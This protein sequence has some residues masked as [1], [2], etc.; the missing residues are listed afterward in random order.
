MAN[1]SKILE[2]AATGL[3]VTNLE[4]LPA[5]DFWQSGVISLDGADT[6]IYD[7]IMIV[8][9]EIVLAASPTDGDAVEFYL[10]AGDDEAS[11]TW[12]GNIGE[13]EGTISTAAAVADV[14][15]ALPTPHHL[16]AYVSGANLTLKGS[17][18]IA[19]PTH[20]VQILVRSPDQ[21]LGTGNVVRYRTA[22]PQLQ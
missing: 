18:E 14:E 17:F 4:S 6:E 1:E 10:A 12:D 2:Q 7:Q 16:Q 8:S 20:E 11:E 9:Y 21:A 3:T 5:G 22:T 15:S 19:I 13:S